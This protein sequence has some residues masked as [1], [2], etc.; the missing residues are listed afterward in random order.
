M[1]SIHIGMLLV[2]VPLVIGVGVVVLGPRLRGLDEEK[3]KEKGS[4]GISHHVLY[5]PF[6]LDS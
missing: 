1:I 6:A 2:T 3:Q 5:R 4:D